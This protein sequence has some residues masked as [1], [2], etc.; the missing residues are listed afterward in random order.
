MRPG[1]AQGP[2]TRA[3]ISEASLATFFSI[4]RSVSPFSLKNSAYHPK[5]TG[6]DCQ[7]LE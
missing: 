7:M 3:Y 5:S 4:Q 1:Q 2:A 6:G